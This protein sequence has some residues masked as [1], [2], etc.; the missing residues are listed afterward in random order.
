M[1]VPFLTPSQPGSSKRDGELVRRKGGGG[2]GRGTSG[3]GSS[4]S[5]STANKGSSWWS[6]S[7]SSS[8]SSTSSWSS[9]WSAGSSKKTDKKK[10]SIWKSSKKSTPGWNKQ[11]GVASMIPA[12]YPFAGRIAGGGTRN[13]VFGTKTYGS[14]YPGIVGRGTSGRGFP[15]FF[16]PLAWPVAGGSAAL[17]LHNNLE[18]GSPGNTTR[19]GGAMTYAIFPSNTTAA[20]SNSSTF[21][22]MADNATVALF[23]LDANLACGALLNSTT[24][25]SNPV[26]FDNST[27][28]PSPEQAIQYY[29]ASSSVLTLD[30]YNNSATYAVEGTPDSSLPESMNRE[31]ATCLNETIA[32]NIPLIDGAL[33][34]APLMKFQL[35]GSVG[36]VLCLL[37]WV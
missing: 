21:R 12:G 17:Y 8:S 34:L 22:F 14:G 1:F 18:Y 24:T 30:G 4:S 11:L 6:S 20:P 32:T 23:I 19:P 33:G 10:S 9:S 16:W 35:F 27:V 5:S 15:F 36:L 28:A 7:S 31:L 37:S 25:S 26:A 2:K 13:D 3:R 29:R